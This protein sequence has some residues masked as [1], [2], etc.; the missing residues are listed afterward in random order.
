M[1]VN[2]YGNKLEPL[3]PPA[4]EPEGNVFKTISHDLT[5]NLELKYEPVGVTVYLETENPSPC[6][7]KRGGMK[8]N[9]FGGGN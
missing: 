8:G 5:D 7:A 6:C 3:K 4:S 1:A 2:E 9:D